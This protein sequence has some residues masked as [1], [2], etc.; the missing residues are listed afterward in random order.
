VTGFM[1][2]FGNIGGFVGPIVVGVAVERWG[3]W[4]I[5]FYIAAAVYAS[6]ALLWLAIDPTRKLAPE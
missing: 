5:P 4:T 2:T 6:G 1:N 3:S